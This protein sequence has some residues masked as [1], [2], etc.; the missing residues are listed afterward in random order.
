[1]LHAVGPSAVDS[2]GL[3]HLSRAFSSRF[4]VRPHQVEGDDGGRSRVKIQFR[5]RDT[6]VRQSGT[7]QAPEQTRA[8]TVV[9]EPQELFASSTSVKLKASSLTVVRQENDSESTTVFQK[10]RLDLH[11]RLSQVAFE[12]GDVQGISSALEGQTDVLERIFDAASLLGDF[13]GQLS[14]EFLGRIRSGLE[15]LTGENGLLGQATS[16]DLKIR[17]KSKTVRIEN[18]EDG[19]VVERSVQR[20]D[21]RV[22]FVSLSVSGEVGEAQDPIEADLEGSHGHLRGLGPVKRF[23]LN[24][25]GQFNFE[26]IA[27]LA[28]EV[29]DVTA[30]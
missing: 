27:A 12:S 30:G 28:D 29:I 5:G 7:I 19:T 18:T 14:N 24:G 9:A 8:A 22:R 11:L 4:H 17:V 25:D 3:S 6:F 16:L 13:S 15:A 10:D 21:I 23:D 20:I 2:R 1:M 26:D